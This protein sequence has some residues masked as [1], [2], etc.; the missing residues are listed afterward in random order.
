MPITRTKSII[1]HLRKLPFLGI[2][3]DFLLEQFHRVPVSDFGKRLVDHC[4]KPRQQS[5]VVELEQ[6]RGGW[7]VQ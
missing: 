5:L 2:F 3:G 1:I 4:L 6:Q 7:R